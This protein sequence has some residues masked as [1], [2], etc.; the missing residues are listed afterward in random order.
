[1]TEQVRESLSAW[2][3]G[4]ASEIEI[5]RLVRHYSADP[6]ADGTGAETLL[7]SGLTYQHVR[8]V[9]RRE[10]GGGISHQTHL[11]L[12]ARISAAIADEP[13]HSAGHSSAGLAAPV[14]VRPVWIKPVGSLAAAA[15]LVVAVFVGLQLGIQ[16]GSDPVGTELASQQ[17]ALPSAR[18]SAALSNPI[19]VQTVS[20]RGAV[21]SAVAPDA[22]FAS[23]RYANDL[24]PA[25][26][27][28]AADALSG[29]MELKELDEA[30]Q[31]QLRAYLR[32][33]DQMTRMNPNSRTVT[34]P[35]PSQP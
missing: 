15:S 10:H 35:S 13:A 20:T 16:P 29:G 31:R 8:R 23:D 33:H 28:D 27:A 26:Y 11:A 3:D 1:M 34:Y 5:H 2:L 9:L 7:A 30:K 6:S 21:P 4:E 32:Q 18:T 17:S 22:S 25:T 14:G 12:H 24:S 19:D